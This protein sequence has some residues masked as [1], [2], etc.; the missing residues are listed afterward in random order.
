MLDFSF[1][2]NLTIAIK[3]TVSQLEK[4]TFSYPHPILCHPSSSQ[5]PGCERDDQEA[6]GAAPHGAGAESLCSELWGRRHRQLRDPDPCAEGIWPFWCCCWAPAGMKNG[7]V[8]PWRDLIAYS[9]A[10]V[11]ALY[12]CRCT[13]ALK[14]LRD[15]P[16]ANASL[17]CMWFLKL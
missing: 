1:G 7:G 5:S 6:A 2:I 10:G 12:T 15:C 3:L 9:A 13:S 14:C 16:G 4:R 17:H 11:L 8:R